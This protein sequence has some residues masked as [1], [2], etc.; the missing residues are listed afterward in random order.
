MK[1]A[2]ASLRRLALDALG[3]AALMGTAVL[4]AAPAAA[5]TR[6]SVNVYGEVTQ[7]VAADLDN[8]GTSAYT[9]LAL[10]VDARAST[11]RIDG[12]ISYRY[13]RRLNW[14]DG[15]FDNDVHSGLA[16][17][18]AQIIPNSL[19]F[20]AG[21]I[22]TR[23][24]SDSRGPIFG[25]DTIDH[26]NIAEVYGVYA[27]PD[28]SRRI[29]GIDVAAAY[30]FG[31]V[32]VDDHSLRG[33][34]LV[35]GQIRLDRYNSSTTHSATASVGQ[36]PGPRPFGWT[37]GAGY[38][39]EDLDRLDQ[40]YE[41]QFIRADVVVPVSAT[42]ALTAGIG[43]EKIESSQQDF[44]RG[45]GGIPILTPGG[46]L[47][48]DPT[49][50][51]LVTFE[52]DGLIYEG[53]IIW[54]PSRRTELQARVGHRY[55]G[56]TFT[57]SFRHRINSA[58]GLNIVVYDTVDSFGRRLVTDLSGVPVNFRIPETG[59]NSGVGGIGGC[60]FGTEPGTGTC[61]DDVFQSV[62]TSNFRNR[63]VSAL[64]SGGRGPWSFG[65]GAGYNNRRYYSPVFTADGTA[66]DRIVD[67]SF[68][69]SAFADR[70]LTPSSSA[71]VNAYATWADSGFRNAGSAFGTGITASYRKQFRER[72]A[73][74]AA[75]GLFHTSSEQF[76]STGVSALVGLR[77]TF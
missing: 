6:T 57:G 25:F 47:I 4:G 68:T 32:S 58:Y 43:Y 17:M 59:L 39:R 1:A 63:G 26:S 24:R 5:Q 52:T 50:P 60:I 44:L 45:T 42:L 61:F 74:T 54:R 19:N 8:G 11:R 72:L 35:P 36:A 21:A 71:S 18:R 7:V 76:D 69:L 51:R 70:R 3:L 34:P 30:R 37:I 56:T 13:E 38:V 40:N 33:L 14:D 65:V 53:G 46:N 23:A 2:L 64:L 10:G 12:Q 67:E 41:G 73:G 28:F 22:A 27:G 9:G 77:Y 31:Y 48:P 49:R 16:Q 66:L 75:V 20:N 29:G 62:T 55:G 15:D